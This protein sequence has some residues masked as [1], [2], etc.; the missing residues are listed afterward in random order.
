M[1]RSAAG[2]DTAARSLFAR[3]YSG[4]IR[5]YLQHRWRGNVLSHDVE[6]ASQEVFIEALKPGGALARGDRRRGDFRSLLYGVTRN[7]ARRFEERAGRAQAR[8][9]EDSVYLDEL[10]DRAAALSAFFDQEWARSLMLEAVQ[11]FERAATMGDETSQ[12]R[13]RVLQMRHDDGLA[14]REIAA[15]LAIPDAAT[16]H[17]D[18]RQA[19][20]EFAGHLRAVVAHHTG[21]MGK[22]ID[23][24]C[25]RLTALLAT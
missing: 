11:R 21:A 8:R 14:V 25:R 19:R 3:Q 10:P 13:F 22:A 16:I 1:L 5:A 17:N 24:E 12:R 6:D 20:R 7:V 15:A 2:G 9:P 4:P 23:D 18:Y